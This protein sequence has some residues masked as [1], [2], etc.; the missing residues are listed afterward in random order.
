MTS[1][2]KCIMNAYPLSDPNETTFK[3]AMNIAERFRDDMIKL[4]FFNDA[5]PTFQ[6]FATEHSTM[7]IDR[8]CLEVFEKSK[9]TDPYA[10]F[11]VSRGWDWR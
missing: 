10:V 8:R 5:S 3:T 7:F 2:L 9:G 11:G 6:K 1:F 4:G